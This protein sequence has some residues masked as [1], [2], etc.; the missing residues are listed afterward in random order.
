MDGPTLETAKWAPCT[1]RAA[2]RFLGASAL[3]GCCFLSGTRNKLH[4]SNTPTL[5]PR[6]VWS[7]RRESRTV[8]TPSRQSVEQA[9]ILCIGNAGGL[10]GKRQA[11]QA[12]RSPIGATCRSSPLWRSCP[13]GCPRYRFKQILQVRRSPPG[14]KNGYLA[15]PGKPGSLGKEAP[16][17][18]GLALPP[19]PG[20]PRLSAPPWPALG[21]PGPP[22]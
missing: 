11:R 13:A 3:L 1:G 10:H 9:A 7:W 18:P 14:V 21:C 2:G 17:G 22:S 8:S 5:P 20:A 4:F 16:P 19:R 15:P 6:A 12:S